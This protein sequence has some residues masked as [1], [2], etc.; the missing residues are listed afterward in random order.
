MENKVAPTF[1]GDKAAYFLYIGKQN[2]T[3]VHWK[4]HKEFSV[5][6]RHFPE[7]AGKNNDKLGIVFLICA[8][9]LYF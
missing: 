7:E 1:T 9:C 5:C 4:D 3:T 6:V 8:M 2:G